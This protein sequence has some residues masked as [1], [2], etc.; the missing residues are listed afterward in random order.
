M[1]AHPEG[2]T[3][4]PS[5]ARLTRAVALA[6]IAVGTVAAY[7]GS[8]SGPALYDDRGS[9]LENPTIRSL[10]TMWS[11]HP[12]GWPVSGRPVL[13][14]SFGLNYALSG[15]DLRSYH[16]VNILIHASAACVLFGILWRTFIVLGRSYERSLA[17]AWASALLWALHPLQTESVAYLSQRAESLMGLFYLLCV[18]AFIRAYSPGAGGKGAGAWALLCVAACAVGVGAKEV[19]AT[20]PLVL[21]AYDRLS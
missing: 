14:A 20:V 15:L 3:A 12:S 11:P 10:S 2:L 9:I 7:R 5:R 19:M 8:L 21:F 13:N 6:S 16:G 1:A 4:S 18:Y 17:L